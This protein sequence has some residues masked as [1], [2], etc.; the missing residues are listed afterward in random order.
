MTQQLCTRTLNNLNDHTVTFLTDIS[1]TSV[2]SHIPEIVLQHKSHD[3]PRIVAMTSYIPLHN[4]CRIP[5]STLLWIFPSPIFLLVFT[6][7]CDE[8]IVREP[9]PVKIILHSSWYR[10][11]IYVFVILFSMWSSVLFFVCFFSTRCCQYYMNY[12]THPLPVFNCWQD[13]PN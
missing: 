13:R 12:W 2:T 3:I 9:F 4:C 7:N 11:L 8:D 5:K 6:V 1:H 10:P